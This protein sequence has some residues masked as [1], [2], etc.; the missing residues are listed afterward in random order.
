[1]TNGIY[2][3]NL[4]SI[5]A[6]H[7]EIWYLQSFDPFTSKD[8]I[9]L[10]IFINILRDHLLNVA[11][12]HASM[13]FI[14]VYLS[15]KTVYKQFSRFPLFVFCWSTG[16]LTSLSWQLATQNMPNTQAHMYTHTDTT[17][18]SHILQSTFLFYRKLET[19]PC[20]CTLL[21]TYVYSKWQLFSKMTLWQAD[22]NFL[23]WF[24]GRSR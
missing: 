5:K 2:V 7:L 16:P 13:R 8:P 15:W 4:E 17:T 3:S 18:S 6:T 24:V 14:N 12:P 23:T 1:M 20:S 19:I 11:H 22:A 10:L 9:W 21:W